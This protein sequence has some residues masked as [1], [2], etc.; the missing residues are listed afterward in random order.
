MTTGRVTTS[1]EVQKRTNK[2]TK[3]E[4]V[5]KG[6]DEVKK[7]T[8]KITK[9][10]EVEKGNE[11]LEDMNMAVVTISGKDSDTFGGQYKGSTGWFNL[12]L[13]FK[14]I[15]KLHTNQTYIKKS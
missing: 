2:I 11:K 14:I 5:V 13:E 10:E 3:S 15:I 12:D 9:S 8:E 1:D 4:E 7:F 6:N